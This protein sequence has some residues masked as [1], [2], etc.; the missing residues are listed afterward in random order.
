[1]KRD[2]SS[3]PIIIADVS[4]AKSISS[5]VS[6]CKVLIN[7]CGPYH[8][9]GEA[10]VHACIQARTH[11]V[12]M[13]YEP[14]YMEKIQMDYGDWARR[15]GVYVVSACGFGSIPIEMGTVFIERNF[16]GCVNSIETFA[17]VEPFRFT[18]LRVGLN[19]GSWQSVI[20]GL[21]F[22]N[23]LI[24]LRKRIYLP[25]MPNYQPKLLN[26]PLLHKSG[27]AND[28]WAVVFP[29]SDTSIAARSQRYLYDY[30][31][32]RPIQLKTYMTFE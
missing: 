5:M 26:R 21:A 4:D 14:Q 30:E 10:A 25:R 6:K 3:I 27:I 9:Y 32:K 28:R 17:E 31:Q 23:E 18:N 29:G 24:K 1:M 15:M 2:L 19:Y 7:L 11:L 13:S 20:Y 16:N 22:T 12:D 8:L